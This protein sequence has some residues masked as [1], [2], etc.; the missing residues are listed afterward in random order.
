MT[1]TQTCW[2]C[3]GAAEGLVPGRG[4]WVCARHGAGD[5]P[6]VPNAN[7]T[8]ELAENPKSRTS[9]STS[10]VSG[11]ANVS[12]SFDARVVDVDVDIDVE[13]DV[14]TL[15]ANAGESSSRSELFAGLERDALRLGCQPVQIDLPDDLSE[16]Q[17]IV[18][19]D[20]LY[21]AG[22]YVVQD[23]PG[24]EFPYSQRWREPVLGLSRMTIWRALKELAKDPRVDIV[25]R[26][27]TDKKHRGYPRGTL[28]YAIRPHREASPP[29]VET[30]AEQPQPEAVELGAV[31]HAEVPVD[32]VPGKPVTA[33]D[34]ASARG[35]H[36]QKVRAVDQTGDER[37]FT[38][39]SSGR[40]IHGW[41]DAS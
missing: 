23:G 9:T 27:E 30:A 36:G 28:L 6:N 14:G 7:A 5:A 19:E 8:R 24:R 11:E 18:A 1:V 38:P 34:G 33:G 13:V 22:V 16:V 2:K 31:G 10:D 39:S 29:S 32:R 26:G 37:L 15:P 40:A 3:G 25:C 35:G 41:E 4:G 12:G 17:R 20:V 21:V